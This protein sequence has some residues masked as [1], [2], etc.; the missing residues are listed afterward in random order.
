MPA[1]SDPRGEY[2]AGWTVSEAAG[3]PAE[4]PILTVPAPSPPASDSQPSTT[5]RTANT[6]STDASIGPRTPEAGTCRARTST[7][8]LSGPRRSRRI[9]RPERHHRSARDLRHHLRAPIRKLVTASARTI[10]WCFQIAVYPRRTH[11]RSATAISSSTRPSHGR[12]RSPQSRRSASHDLPTNMRWLG[13]KKYTGGGDRPII[14][15]QIVAYTLAEVAMKIEAGR[16]F[17]WK[18][19]HYH[20][21]HNARWPCHRPD[22]EGVLQRDAVHRRIPGHEGRWRQRA[23]QIPST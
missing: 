11:S 17:A 4:L 3:T 13:P 14:N 8:V 9:S 23:G 6:S 19:A 7:S 20:D 2:L 15:H 21:L 22:G 18:A 1:T 10:P 5:G 16:A 12:D